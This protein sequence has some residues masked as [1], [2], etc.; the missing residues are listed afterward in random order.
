MSV[1]PLDDVFAAMRTRTA[2]YAR[3]E[4][5]APW[6]VEFVRGRAARFGLVAQGGCWLSVDGEAPVWLEAGDCYVIASGLRYVLQDDPTSPTKFCFDALREH[7][8]HVVRHGGGGIPATVITGWFMFDTVGAR[9]LIDLMPRLILARVAE[10]ESQMI[11]ATLQLLAFETGQRSLG[12]SIVVS[13]LADI[14]FIQAIRAYADRA[15][16]EAGGW[17]GA[18]GDSRLAPVLSAIHAAV[19]HGW[20]V[21]ELA[22]LAGMSRSSFAARFRAR[23]GLTPLDYVTRWRMYRAGTMLRQSSQPIAEI[24]YR[25]GYD[26]ESAFSKAFRRVTGVSPGRYRR[27]SGDKTVPAPASTALRQA[28]AALAR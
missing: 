19:D 13:R 18:L 17:L 22:R 24:A 1:D 21:D 3:F 16:E 25:V 4:G 9:P 20:T 8:H 14:L 28:E 15:G 7:K 6:G 12:T 26:N 23:V 27:A 5:S 11:Q 10:D 2:L